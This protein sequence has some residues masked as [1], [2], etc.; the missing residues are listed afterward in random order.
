TVTAIVR[1]SQGRTIFSGN[2]NTI[3]NISTN[4][5]RY[6]LARLGANGRL[7][8][9]WN[10]PFANVSNQI[11]TLAV[12][13]SDRVPVGGTF[14]SIGNPA[15]PN[16]SRLARLDATTGAV[17]TS[18]V[19]PTNLGNVNVIHVRADGRILVGHNSGLVLL[20]STGALAA[21]FTY[22]GFNSVFAIQP[23]DDGG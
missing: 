21:G 7:D 23:L 1:D 10:S 13:A 11:L 19:P 6:T 4:V 9:G 20:E 12:D 15:V 16:T 14:S 22:S 8:T 3:L 5:T 18:F 2:F 17:D